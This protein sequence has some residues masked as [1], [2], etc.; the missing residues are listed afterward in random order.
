MVTGTELF[1]GIKAE[2]SFG[3]LLMAG[4][5]GIYI[6]MI[7]DVSVSLVPVSYNEAERMVRS[8]KGYA[9]IKGTRGQQ[10]VNETAFIDIICRLSA[11]TEAAPEIHELDLNP[12][13]GTEKLVVAVDA[14]I[15]IEK[16]DK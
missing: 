1:A 5:G 6:E 13:M 9:V 8:L 15:R 11:L 14:R 12:L 4:L 7:K 16:A 2:G 3:H 10:G